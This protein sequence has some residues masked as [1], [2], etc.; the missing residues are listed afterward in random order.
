MSLQKDENIHTYTL[1][2]LIVPQKKVYL[3]FKCKKFDE[4]PIALTCLPIIFT[5]FVNWPYEKSSQAWQG[6]FQFGI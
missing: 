3:V 2:W 5:D 4:S 6:H 1:D